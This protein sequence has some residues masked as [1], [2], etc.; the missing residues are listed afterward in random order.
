MLDQRSDLFRLRDL[1]WFDRCEKFKFSAVCPPKMQDEGVRFGKRNAANM[2]S[3]WSTAR[4]FYLH[5]DLYALFLFMY[6]E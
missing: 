3:I 6:F 1:E 2:A 5:L 4:L